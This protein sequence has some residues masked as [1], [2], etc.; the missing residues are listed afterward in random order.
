MIPLAYLKNTF[1]LESALQSKVCF[2]FKKTV[3]ACVWHSLDESDSL[4]K[5][6]R[7]SSTGC[8]QMNCSACSRSVANLVLIF[9]DILKL[10]QRATK[11][12]KSVFCCFCC[13]LACF[14][15]SLRKESVSELHSDFCN[16]KTPCS[17]VA[18]SCVLGVMELRKRWYKTE[19]KGFPGGAVVK[20]PPANAGDT[21]LSPG[22]GRS[23]MLRSN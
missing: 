4:C 16:Q 19:R 7:L 11:T 18:C 2:V 1:P 14:L 17:C 12:Q 10:P 3:W 21:G 5:L 13:L 9:K 22:P 15:G 8:D 23:H 20:N 6:Y